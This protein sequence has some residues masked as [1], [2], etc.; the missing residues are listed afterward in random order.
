MKLPVALVM[1]QGKVSRVEA[2]SRLKRTK[3]NVRQAIDAD[4]KF[5]AKRKK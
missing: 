5:T 2:T 1:L 3:G 4:G